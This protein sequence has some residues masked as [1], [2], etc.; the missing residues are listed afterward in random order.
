MDEPTPRNPS[1]KT[2]FSRVKPWLE[3]LAGAV[4]L[5]AGIQILRAG[6][7]KTRRL[8][9]HGTMAYVAGITVVLLAFLLLRGR[10][11][12][13]DKGRNWTPPDVIA[14]VLAVLGFAA[15]FAVKV[16]AFF[17]GHQ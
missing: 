9:F 2:P 13:T 10:I 14:G 1:G 12:A 15:C 8:D 4:L 5:F 3:R 7:L 17:R 6:E 16:L 11:H